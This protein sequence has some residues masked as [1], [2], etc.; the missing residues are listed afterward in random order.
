[1][2]GWPSGLR[3][4][5]QVLVHVCGRG[6]KSH[7][8]QCLLVGFDVTEANASLDEMEASTSFQVSIHVGM[9]SPPSSDT[10][11]WFGLLWQRQMQALNTSMYVGM[12][13]NPTSDSAFWLGLMWQKQVQALIVF[14][15]MEASTSPT[16]SIHVGAGSDPSSD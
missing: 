6:F 10:A 4:Q 8:W 3:R 2:S 15:V 13:S 9:S 12:G 7:F 11:L 1:M 5:T 16:V 14:D